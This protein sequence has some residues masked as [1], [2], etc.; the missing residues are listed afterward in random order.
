MKSSAREIP[1]APTA[2]R[3]PML[4]F[5]I[6]AMERRLLPDSAVRFGIRRLCGE[7]LAEAAKL[8][9]EE[10]Q[11]QDQKYLEMLRTS[12]VAVH[13]KD[14]NQ[15]HYELPASFFDLVLGENKKYSCAFYNSPT[16]TLNQAEDNA[17]A[18][19][20]ERADLKDG[21]QILELGCGWGS[22]TLAMARKF[23]N[24]K[25]I[26]L[27]NS[28]PQREFIEAKAKSLGLDN[29]RILTR[30]VAEVVDLDKEFGAFD[31]VVSVEMLEHMRN[32]EALF[33]RISK[34]LKPG[35]KFFAHIFTHREMS[36]LF[37]VDGTNN[38]MGKYFFTGGQM[39]S[40]YLLRSFQRNLTLEKQWTW[41]GKNY[42]KTS[43]DWLDNLDKNYD[44]IIPIMKSVY[45]N[46]EAERWLQRWRVFFMSCA[47]LFGYA[48]GSQWFVSHYLF[49]KKEA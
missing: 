29:V 4:E 44:A 1:L 48:D 49:S 45:G 41:D 39:P 17:L 27:S 43:N 12:P 30:D 6:D 37:D 36:Y 32:Y 31:R 38:W 3:E 47:E 5:L 28:K 18:I 15:Q 8:T 19:T 34:W 24:A 20:I 26:A 9:T 13:T 23:P 25:I 14:A 2:K 11:E 46:E 22:I 35:G 33:A 40:R 10:V 42:E 21:M 7:R 16:E